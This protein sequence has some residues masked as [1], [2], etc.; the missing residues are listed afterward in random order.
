MR[1]ALKAAADV[2]LKAVDIPPARIDVT[3]TSNKLR[4]FQ[5]DFGL[6]ITAGDDFDISF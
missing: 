3:I 4:Y 1:T 2:S 5:P 6:M